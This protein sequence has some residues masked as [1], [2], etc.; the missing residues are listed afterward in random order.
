MKFSKVLRYSSVSVAL[1]AGLYVA[2]PSGAAEPI[3]VGAVLSTSGPATFLGDPEEKT[4]KLYVDRINAEGGVLGRKLELF[5]YDDGSEPGKANSFTKRLIFQ[6]KVDF[7]V[8]GSTTGSTMAM[9][10]LVEANKIPFMSMGGANVIVHPVHPY[11]FKM[12]HSDTMA[13]EKVLTDMKSRGFTKFAL[14][15]DTGGYGK[16]G[17]AETL[18]VAK[19][20]G[21]TV[22]SDQS[23]GEKDTDM[24]PQLQ[25]V[26]S[27][28]AQAV[29]IFGT[30]QAPAIATKNYRQLGIT[31]PL[32]MTHGQASAVYIKLAGAASEGVRMPTPALLVADQLANNDPQKK[33]G[34]D[35]THAFESTYK[36]PVSTFGGY[37][38]DGLMMALA[39]VK[40]AGTTDGPKVRDAVEHLK[41]FDGVSGVYNMTPTDHMGLNLSA[42]H[43]V[44]IKDGKF[45]KID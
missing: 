14:L 10:P 12:P 13:A 2:A 41:N 18:K 11:T 4:L 17:H 19:K 39:A 44:V 1:M 40:K 5:E 33:I 45:V 34:L 7:I 35:Y 31:L 38:Y 9:I 32:Y 15:S 20:M 36:I 26:K 24:T 23:Y 43:M 6:D 37:A 22:V 27:T 30:G 29:L 21:M 42:F 28:D 8:G 3:R 16:S 25:K